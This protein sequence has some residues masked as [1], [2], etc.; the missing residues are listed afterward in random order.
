MFTG[1]NKTVPGIIIP[2]YAYPKLWLRENEW[3]RLTA[4]A[5]QHPVLDIRV[6][7]NPA[8]GPGAASGPDFENYAAGITLLREAGVS[9]VGYV[10]TDYAEKPLA[11][12]ASE[13]Q[14]YRQFYPGK[15]SGIFFDQM[16]YSP[17]Q[18]SYY[19]QSTATA[20]GAGFSYT[21]GNPGV[22]IPA[23]YAGSC[24]IINV[25]ENAGYP[26]LPGALARLQSTSAY[27]KREGYSVLAYNVERLDSAWLQ[28]V[29]GFVGFVYVAGRG[30]E[31][32][33]DCLPPFFDAFLQ[34]VALLHEVYAGRGDGR[35]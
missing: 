11:A 9:V 12:V 14:N 10:D 13:I 25:Y 4:S 27:G 15:L 33:W 3:T 5:R 19:Q 6:V 31:R 35:I 30:Q 18:E 22:V 1:S 24:T 17:R 28:E 2:F 23:S 32:D 34:E 7:I 29:V 21:I 8:N 20:T 26:E 16:A